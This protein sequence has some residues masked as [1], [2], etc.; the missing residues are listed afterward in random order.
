V[1]T[2]HVNEASWSNIRKIF[3]SLELK[4]QDKEIISKTWVE[5]ATSE[6]L[7]HW[8]QKNNQWQKCI[9]HPGNPV[10][11][12]LLLIPPLSQTQPEAYNKR[13]KWYILLQSAFPVAD[14]DREGWNVAL[15]GQRIS[16]ILWVSFFFSKMEWEQYLTLPQSYKD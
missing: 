11:C 8:V 16:N 1:L 7:W 4:G 3:F 12:N 14:Q 6:D 9:Q 13:P 15:D 5:R 10:V 2:I